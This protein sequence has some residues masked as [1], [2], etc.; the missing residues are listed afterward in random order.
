MAQCELL[1]YEVPATS[2]YVAS[3][4]FSYTFA[5]TPAWSNPLQ[6]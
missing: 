5:D 1:P 2:H 3:P 6:L 4:S